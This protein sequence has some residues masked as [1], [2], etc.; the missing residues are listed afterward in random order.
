MQKK[1]KAI[2]DVDDIL[3]GLNERIANILSYDINKI[4][5]FSIRKCYLIEED[6][7]NKII[8]LYRDVNIFK[9]MDFYNG[10]ENLMILEE[11]GV[12]VQICSNSMTKEIAIEK[13]EQLL[14]KI[15]NLREEQ[16]QMNI[17]SEKTHHQK[18]MDNGVWVLVDDSPYNIAA[19]EA[20]IDIMRPHPWNMSPAGKEIYRYKNPIFIPTFTETLDFVYKKAVT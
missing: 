20:E 12:D 17:I 1:K 19:S 15:I 5:N 8:D 6:T 11:V 16:L 10:V 18:K 3:W 7:Q 2:F 14:K 13:T 4:T 9:N